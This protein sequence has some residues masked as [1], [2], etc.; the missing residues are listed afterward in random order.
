GLAE[1]AHRQGD[2]GSMR[3]YLDQAARCF[4][5]AAQWTSYRLSEA[6]C[7]AGQGD[8]AGARQVIGQL[9]QRDGELTPGLRSAFHLLRAQAGR[10]AGAER[11]AIRE[12]FEA[13]VR[14]ARDS[15]E[16]GMHI[17][18]QTLYHYGD[19]Q[20]AV[21]GDADS[22]LSEAERIFRD[23]DNDFWLEKIETARNAPPS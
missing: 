10:A 16:G 13:A 21:A 15:A 4:S 9:Q 3:H 5:G 14:L 7:L 23:L 18:A 19:W 1:M 11:Q 2:Y 20:I 22:V 12:D 17:L 8:A 6:Y